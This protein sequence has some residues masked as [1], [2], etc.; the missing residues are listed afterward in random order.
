M[1]IIYA[2]VIG[3]IIVISLTALLSCNRKA[4]TERTQTHEVTDQSKTVDSLNKVVKTWSDAYEELLKTTNS[5]GVV[6]ESMPCDS[7]KIGGAGMPHVIIKPDGTKEF[8]GPIKSYKDDASKY[9]RTIFSM[10]GTI[11]SMNQLI[12]KDTAHH[13]ASTETMVRTV[14]IVTY[15]IWLVILGP[16]F[17]LLWLNERFSIKKIPFITKK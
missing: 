1:K 9:Q 16:L 17:F 3:V 4:H 10:Q 12:K 6:F 13:E 8:S 5:T 14:K 7:A 11:D 15:P 2:V